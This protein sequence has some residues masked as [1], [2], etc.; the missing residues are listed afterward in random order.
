[1][2]IISG[3]FKGKKLHD[4][5]NKLTRPLKDRVRES[6][7][8][9][10][11]H[12]NI[13]KNKILSSTV[14]DL[15][16]GSGSFGIECLSRGA[17]KVFFCE[18]YSPAFKILKKNLIQLDCLNKS[19]LFNMTVTNFINQ[20]INS[21]LKYDFIFLDPPYKEEKINILFELI[22]KNKILNKDGVL[23]LHRNKKTIDVFPNQFKILSQRVYGLS[24][25][26][27]GKF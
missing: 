18:S 6:I 9:I 16:S 22:I 25:I 4:P 21:Y 12:S 11:E 13:I 14:L 27:F 10:I 8:N 24:K 2:R 1:M 5:K 26:Y 20:S 7:F 19:E 3:K 23:I 15:Y 17:S